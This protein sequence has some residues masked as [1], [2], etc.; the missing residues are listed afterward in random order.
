MKSLGNE[1]SKVWLAESGI[2]VID[3]RQLKFPHEQNKILLTRP[4]KSLPLNYF[5]ETLAD[6][7]PKAPSR[8]IWLS[9]W[10]TYPLS[11][12]R[13]VERIRSSYGETKPIIESPGLLFEENTESEN[14]VFAGVFFLS[15]AFAWSGYIVVKNY[16]D[17]IYTFDTFVLFSCSTSGRA[18]EILGIADKFD[19]QVVEKD[20]P[21]D[22]G[23]SMH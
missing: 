9:D 1:A 13:I 12:T 2:Q 15:M 6:W 14:A 16:P 4:E 23:A 11:Q 10:E 8:L 22:R 19:L 20:L 17:Y 7:L 3:R 21:Q 18:K 5:A